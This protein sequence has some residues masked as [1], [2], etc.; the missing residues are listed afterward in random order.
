MAPGGHWVNA[1][2]STC[3]SRLTPAVLARIHI[4]ARFGTMVIEEV[5]I[6]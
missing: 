2:G 6:G 5:F 4:V 3:A 1:D